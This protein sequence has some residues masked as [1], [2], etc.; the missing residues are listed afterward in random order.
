MNMRTV[1]SLAR[2]LD[3]NAPVGTADLQITGLAE[4]GAATRGE[5]AVVFGDAL[6]RGSS[7]CEASLIVC[8]SSCEL[9]PELPGQAL[10]V[11]D[12][13]KAFV[14]LLQE[15]RPTAI[16]PPGV[17]P[18][19]VVHAE[20]SIATGVHIGPLVVVDAGARI[21][22]DCVVASDLTDLSLN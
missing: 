6:P 21:G 15:F 2:L 3:A 16:E 13:G 20:A 12:P 17:H 7:C 11:A 5:V 1:A 14:L 4:P 22:E 8:S 9:P 10:A 19:A 18:S